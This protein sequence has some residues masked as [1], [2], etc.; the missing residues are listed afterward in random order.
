MLTFGDPVLH[1]SDDLPAP[2]AIIEMVNCHCNGKL[3][4]KN[5]W[6]CLCCIECKNDDEYNCNPLSDESTN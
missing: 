5:V 2:K 1:T 3:L 6:L 4:V